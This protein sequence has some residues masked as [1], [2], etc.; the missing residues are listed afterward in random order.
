MILSI[1][2]RRL[3]SLKH[4][5]GEYF[6]FNGKTKYWDEYHPWIKQ[7][8]QSHSPL[9]VQ[10]QSICVLQEARLGYLLSLSY[11]GEDIIWEVDQKTLEQDFICIE[12]PNDLRFLDTDIF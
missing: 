4:K 7:I 2:D 8:I 5:P 3:N 9:V 1:N 11:S 10:I 6:V 12:N